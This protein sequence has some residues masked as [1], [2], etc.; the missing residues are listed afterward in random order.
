MQHLAMFHS[1]TNGNLDTS[2]V[3]LDGGGPGDEAS[4]EKEN[5]V[6]HIVFGCV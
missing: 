2:L 5:V 4:A 6:R 3:E 1:L